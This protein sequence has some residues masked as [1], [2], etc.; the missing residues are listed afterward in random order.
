MPPPPPFSPEDIKIKKELFNSWIA[1]ATQAKLIT[2]TES[3]HYIHYSEP[4][5]VIE[6]ITVMINSNKD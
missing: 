2:T 1:S 3:G 5:I 4:N 6:A